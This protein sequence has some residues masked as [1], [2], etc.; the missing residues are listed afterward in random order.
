ME[1]ANIGNWA[2]VPAIPICIP[3]SNGGTI[4]FEE[5][6]GNTVYGQVNVPGTGGWQVWQTIQHTVTLTSGNHEFAIAALQG[7]FNINWFRI[8]SAE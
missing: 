2:R 6:G 4:Q 7:G 1:A 8:K 5:R 3:N